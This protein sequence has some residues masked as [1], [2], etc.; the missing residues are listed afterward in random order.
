MVLPSSHSSPSSAWTVPSPQCGGGGIV[1]VVVVLVDVVVVV[2]PRVEL[3]GV[4]VGVVVV[5]GIGTHWQPVHCSPGPQPAVASQPSPSPGSSTPSP[6][7]V[8][9]CAETAWGPIFFALMLPENAVQP[10]AIEPVSLIAFRFWHLGQTTLTLVPVFVPFTLPCRGPP[11]ESPHELMETFLFV[12]MLKAPKE[13]SP[14]VRVPGI[15]KRPTHGG[16]GF[17]ATMDTPPVTQK[18]AVRIVTVPRGMLPPR[19]SWIGGATRSRD[20]WS[21]ASRRD[22]VWHK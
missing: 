12:P 9:T 6:Q 19:K 17:A 21:P 16:G 15:A 10:G 14:R 13:R 5:V 2:A 4:M 11:L 20:R 22:R 3:V 1:V 8:E 7:P 18:A